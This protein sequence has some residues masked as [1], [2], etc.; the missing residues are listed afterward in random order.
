MA[1]HKNSSVTL[2][3]STWFGLRR[4]NKRPT[5]CSQGRLEDMSL[6]SLHTICIQLEV[7]C[8]FHRFP[9]SEICLCV[10]CLLNCLQCVT[11]EAVSF[12]FRDFNAEPELMPKTPSQKKNSRRKRVSLGRQEE[13]QARRRFHYWFHCHIS[14]NLNLF[15]HVTLSIIL[16]MSLYCPDSQRE[17]AVIFVAP[18]S[19]H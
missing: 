8:S 18:L 12:H 1:K 10:V 14:L 6:M 7:S 2:I 4:S 3:M 17:S 15:K 13:N 9:Y 16:K 19:S 5:A 11:N